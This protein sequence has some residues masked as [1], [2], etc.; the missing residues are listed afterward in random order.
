[1][2]ELCLAR[3]RRSGQQDTVWSGDIQRPERF[4]VRQRQFDEFAYLTHSRV[5][6]A[7]IV[8]PDCRRITHR[9]A[10]RLVERSPREA[11]GGPVTN[12]DR[13]VIGVRLGNVDANSVT[14]ICR[15]PARTIV[16]VAHGERLSGDEDAIDEC[17]GKIERDGLR[18]G[19]REFE[20]QSIGGFRIDCGDGYRLPDVGT[21][22]LSKRSSESNG[23]LIGRSGRS[24]PDASRDGSVAD[25][26]TN[27]VSVSHSER[28]HRG[29]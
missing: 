9:G 8:V 27:D 20:R 25:R 5:E 4:R 13:A 14:G 23:V 28:V 17:A 3:P 15:V 19:R 18:S 10:F 21:Q 1:V 11:N 26:D 24:G 16:I 29:R 6:P 22:R 7:D 12:D 2:D